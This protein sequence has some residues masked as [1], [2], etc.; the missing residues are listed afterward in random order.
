MI[1]FLNSEMT[2]LKRSANATKRSFPKLNSNDIKNFPIP[3][4]DSIN[5]NLVIQLENNTRKILKEGEVYK[6][7]LDN[8]I[9]YLR[10]NYDIDLT[11]L[12]FKL[13][14]SIQKGKDEF[15]KLLIKNKLELE[16][17]NIFDHM[18]RYYEKLGKFPK[19]V[20]NI[21][22]ENDKLVYKL[23]N[24]PDSKINEIEKVIQ[25]Y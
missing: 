8:F 10:I 18:M 16:K 23:Y 3:I 24:I 4:I 2:H 1:Y 12:Y 20:D 19:L 25:Y 11:D 21:I 14:Q 15:S 13:N 17:G 22:N 5:I 6:K 9:D 7:D